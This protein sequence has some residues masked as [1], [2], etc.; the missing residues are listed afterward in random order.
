MFVK[1]KITYF[2]VSGKIEQK[3]FMLTGIKALIPTLKML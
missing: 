1:Y 2:S 3:F